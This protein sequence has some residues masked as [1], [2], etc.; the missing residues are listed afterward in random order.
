MEKVSLQ[1]QEYLTEE[2]GLS[3][4]F[5]EERKKRRKTKNEGGVWNGKK[6]SSFLVSHDYGRSG[7]PT[8]G[9]WTPSSW[10]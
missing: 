1:T 9:S 5:K 7:A 2:L 10:M 6:I 4:W 8:A 3:Q